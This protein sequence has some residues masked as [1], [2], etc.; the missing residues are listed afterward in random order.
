MPPPS[1]SA[2]K[3]RR[4]PVELAIA[5]ALALL[6]YLLGFALAQLALLLGQPIGR[7]RH[8]SQSS[9]PF[10]A[11]FLALLLPCSRSSSASLLEGDGTIPRMVESLASAEGTRAMAK[12][13]ARKMAA[14]EV[15]IIF[16]GRFDFMT[17]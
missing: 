7:G 6:G 16:C 11:T 17:L 2:R 15:F 9:L 8:V 3:S 12:A 14:V 1:A 5:L 4:A 13:V 10:L